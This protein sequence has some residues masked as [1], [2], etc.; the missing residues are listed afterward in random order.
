MKADGGA[1]VDYH[2]VK[3]VDVCVLKESKGTGNKRG[4]YGF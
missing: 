3:T 2:S 1:E 4:Q